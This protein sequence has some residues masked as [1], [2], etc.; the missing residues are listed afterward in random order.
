MLTFQA[1]LTLGIASTCTIST[2]FVLSDKRGMYLL[3]QVLGVLMIF[4][5]IFYPVFLFP[6]LTKGYSPYVNVTD[7]FWL[8]KSYPEILFFILFFALVVTIYVSSLSGKS[9][10]IGYIIIGGLIGLWMPWTLSDHPSF[11]VTLFSMCVILLEGVSIIRH[12]TRRE[13]IEKRCLSVVT[14]M[15]EATVEDVMREL[16]V[17]DYEADRLLFNLWLRGLLE[18][19]E[20]G[21]RMVYRVSSVVLFLSRKKLAS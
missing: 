13:A 15:G 3:E 17:P 11:I 8:F 20:K 12:E 10:G 19:Y 18:R 16:G 2:L 6:Y 9:L 7:E 14:K 21:N 4:F 1:Y 5:P